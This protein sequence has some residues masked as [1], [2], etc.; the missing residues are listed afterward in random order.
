M[1]KPAITSASAAHTQKPLRNASLDKQIPRRE[2]PRIEIY[3]RSKVNTAEQYDWQPAAAFVRGI[4]IYSTISMTQTVYYNFISK[5][6][7]SAWSTICSLSH[8]TYRLTAT[9]TP[10][11]LKPPQ[12][13]P[14]DTIPASTYVPLSVWQASG[15]PPSPL[16]MST[17]S[18]PPA[19]RKPSR[20]V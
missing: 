14:H 2:S 19:H 3:R 5:L 11:V 1:R 15:D 17:A 10:G 12:P 4:C 7:F 13:M 9:Y 20:R 8:C 6:S 16:H 18:S